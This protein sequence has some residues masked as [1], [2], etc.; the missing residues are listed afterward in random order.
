MVG[1]D[2]QESRPAALVRRR[3]RKSTSPETSGASEGAWRASVDSS[4]GI[5]DG[6]RHPLSGEVIDEEHVSVVAPG[7]P[8]QRATGQRL[9]AVPIVG[10]GAT[11]LLY[12]W[13]RRCGQ[14][15]PALGELLLAGAIGEEAVV[16]N[17]VEAGR[18]HVEEHAPDELG[19]RQR[20]GLL[21][22][23]AGPAVVGVAEAHGAVVEAPP[24]IFAPRPMSVAVPI[25]AP[26]PS[27][28]RWSIR[29][30]SSM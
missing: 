27:A 13:R 5:Q 25:L 12:R 29:T 22:G 19:R 17:A 15:A 21:T 24:W 7:T 9:I 14:Q 3:R 26:V 8:P 10:G 28:N 1:G 18:E 4:R 30:S 11:G 20:H 6:R 2:G 23:R 16:A